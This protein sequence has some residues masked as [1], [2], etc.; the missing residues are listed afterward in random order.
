M[1]LVRPIGPKRDLVTILRLFRLVAPGFP[2]NSVPFEG[3]R[4][5]PWTSRFTAIDDMPERGEQQSG[6]FLVR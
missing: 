2:Q 6:V 1:N 3:S 4:N 5:D